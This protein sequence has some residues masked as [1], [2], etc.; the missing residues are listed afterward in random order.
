[1]LPS[2][3]QRLHAPGVLVADGAMGTMLIQRGLRAGD[4]PER[5][6]L[7][8]PAVL[9]EIARLYLEAGAEIVQTN[10]FGASPLKLA[11]Y[12]LAGQ[13][14][15]INTEAV[16]AVKRAVDG[17]AYVSASVGP[18]GK[19]MEPYGDV[20][21]DVVFDSYRRQ[22]DT[23]NAAGVDMICIETM[24]D[25][26]EAALAIRA[27]RSLGGNVPVA[28]SMTFDH[29]PRGFRTVMGTTVTEAAKRLADAGADVIGSNCGNG[30]VRMVAIA[31]EFQ[32]ASSLPLI[33]QSNAGLPVMK[34][35]EAHY[36]E[37][38]AFM[39]E[40]SRKLLAA[41]VK[42]IGGCCGTTP[43]HI[44]EIAAAIRPLFH[45]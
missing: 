17:R 4:C 30:I 24:M 9:E 16:E 18:S 34:D 22:M 13:T 33:I 41:G 38:P 42:I 31:E 14:E 15:A 28:A 3:F 20:A 35:G 45:G 44:R 26:R 21:E 32:R 27:V 29:T 23:L 25:V 40:E 43:E 12:D 1:M 6:N 5:I 8:S 2:L 7:E 11:A 10:T 39:A 37:T 36:P 19:I